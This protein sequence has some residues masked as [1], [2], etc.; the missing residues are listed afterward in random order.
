MPQIAPASPVLTT[1]NQYG[2]PIFAWPYHPMIEMEPDN[3]DPPARVTGKATRMD[4]RHISTP[5]TVVKLTASSGTKG[6]ASF[7]PWAFDIAF[8]R[9]VGVVE[10][11]RR[12]CPPSASSNESTE[13]SM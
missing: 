1:G 9:S 6:R 11:G 3:S 13:A 7:T 4:A 2:T 10:N 5:N 8:L 12:A